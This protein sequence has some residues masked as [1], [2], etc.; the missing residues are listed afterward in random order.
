MQYSWD[1]PAGCVLIAV[2][3][4]LYH[5]AA[6]PILVF[7]DWDAVADG[8]RPFRV[9][10]DACIDGF[11]AALEQE[12]LDGS[13]RPIA[14]ISRATPSP[15][16]TWVHTGIVFVVLGRRILGGKPGFFQR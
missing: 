5:L 11:G 7:P 10:C 16:I 2:P 1:A 12:Q 9:Y 13:V 4:A 14:Y 3:T 15:V 8:S 6:P